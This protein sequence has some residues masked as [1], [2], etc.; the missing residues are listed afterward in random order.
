MSRA[1]LVC[2]PVRQS[3]HITSRWCVEQLRGVLHF[4]LYHRLQLPVPYLT[5]GVLVDQ[6]KRSAADSSGSKNFFLERQRAEAIQTHK[7]VENVLKCLE[8]SIIS[9]GLDLEC[10]AIVFGPTASTMAKEVYFVSLPAVDREH[11]NENHMENLQRTVAQTMLTLIT[12][13]RLSTVFSSPLPLTNVHILVRPRQTESIE[14]HLNGHLD[15]VAN[16]QLPRSCKSYLI[17]LDTERTPVAGD[18]N[19]ITCRCIETEI[20]VFSD[21]ECGL[22]MQCSQMTIS[23]EVV[24]P[25]TPSTVTLDAISSGRWYRVDTTIKGFKDVLSNGR[26]IWAS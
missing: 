21:L 3:V 20:Q 5:F 1:D 10:A 8:Q 2:I 7:Q 15:E 13:D 6:L 24:R 9:D 14:P 12:D 22:E 18:L 16:L 19:S 25:T 11:K 4:L 23:E 17:D 26:K